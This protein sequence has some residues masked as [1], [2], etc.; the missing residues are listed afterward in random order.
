MLAM[1]IPTRLELLAHIDAFLE[2]HHMAETRLGRDAT[3]EASLVS[4]IRKGRSPGIDTLN[5]LA[6][7]M[8]EHD[9][10]LSAEDRSGSATES[11][12]NIRG[13]SPDAPGTQRSPFANAT[14]C[15]SGGVAAER[16]VA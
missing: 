2:R 3:G 12:G 16:E 15:D 11:A 4:T 9:A 10:L 7:F 1:L 5:K 14:G 13:E 8:D 6:A